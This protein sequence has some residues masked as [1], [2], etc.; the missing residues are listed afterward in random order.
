MESEDRNIVDEEA[1]PTRLPIPSTRDEQ[2]TV[3]AERPDWWEHL[4]FAGVLQQGLVELEGKWQDHKLKLPGG[5]RRKLDR[6]ST[7]G[8]IGSEVSW[9]G[10]QV[11]LLGRILASDAQEVAFG[12]LGESGDPVLIVHVARHLVKSYESLLDWAATLRNTSVP[13]VFDDVLEASACL[14]DAP[15]MQIRRLIQ[16]Y[17]DEISRLP[18]LAVGASEEHPIKITL[19]I[20]V[21]LDEAAKKRLDDAIHKATREIQQGG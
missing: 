16:T 14:V 10:K 20:T 5:T 12:A 9:M 8:F 6:D 21:V 17:I 19:E 1:I 11:E 13:S 15:L 7:S 2:D 3:V 18:E 4:L